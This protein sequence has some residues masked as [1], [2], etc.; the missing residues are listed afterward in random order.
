MLSAVRLRQNV[1]VKQYVKQS[2]FD[3]SKNQPTH[4]P[5]NMKITPQRDILEN[6]GLDLRSFQSL[7]KTHPRFY[8]IIKDR[9][10]RKQL[11]DVLLGKKSMLGTPDDIIL[12][13]LDTNNRKNNQSYLFVVNP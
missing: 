3:F 11:C 2:N 13:L 9:N 12:W 4:L 6:G 5:Y 1:V 10:F 8:S 7:T